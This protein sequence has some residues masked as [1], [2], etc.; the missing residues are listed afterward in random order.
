MWLTLCLQS[1]AGVKQAVAAGGG[2][3]TTIEEG[4]L[5]SAFAVAVARFSSR[6]YASTDAIRARYRAPNRRS[7][8]STA[9]WCSG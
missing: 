3:K 6:A 8:R 7:I 9:T 5:F 1:L 4:A 2:R